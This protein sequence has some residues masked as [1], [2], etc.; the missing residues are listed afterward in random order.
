MEGT[1]Q[2]DDKK[3]IQDD[4]TGD[5]LLRLTLTRAKKWGERRKGG[6]IPDV[7]LEMV[8]RLEDRGVAKR[9]A[10]YGKTAY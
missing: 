7:K 8:R 1:K 4:R 2:K 3:Q 10:S 5:T 6:G 9:G